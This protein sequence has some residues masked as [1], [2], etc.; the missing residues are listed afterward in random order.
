[1]KRALLILGFVAATAVGL[2]T[3]SEVK[4]VP[5]YQ[6]PCFPVGNP[7]YKFAQW[8]PDWGYHIGNDICHQ[9]NIAVY[10]PADGVVVYSA[11]TPASYRW[12]NLILIEH[13]QPDG[14]IVVS[15]HGHLA[16]NRQV[17]AGQG[18]AKGQLI[19]FVGA[20]GV[21]NGSWDPHNHFGIH[22]GPYNYP[23]GAYAPWVHG[24]EPRCCAGWVNSLDYARDR[25][26]AHDNIP[27]DVLGLTEMTYF[28]KLKLNFRARNTG[29]Q[30][31]K[32][33]GPTPTRLGTLA[34]NDRPSVFSKNGTGT[35]WVG[36][37]RI[38]L[39]ADTPPEG[40]GEFE[41]EFTSHEQPGQYRECFN[42]VTDNVGWHPNRPFC[43]TINLLA[44]RYHAQYDHQ[45]T[46]SASDPANR[47]SLAS[48]NYMLP[49]QT[50]NLKAYI[51][52][53]GELPWDVGPGN[54]VRLGTS[55]PLDRGSA[56]ATGGNT[57]IPNSENWPAANRASFIDGRYDPISGTITPVAAGDQITMDQIAVF[58]FT[59]TA[60]QTPGSYREYFNP[61]LEGKQWLN[62][63]GMYFPL[64]VLDNGHHYEHVSQNNPPPVGDST[65]TVTAKVRLRNS[66]QTSWPV[67]GN[68]RLGTDRPMDSASGFHAPS[69]PD[70]W[71][72]PTRLSAVD[73]NITTPGKTSIDPG[74]IAE[75]EFPMKIPPDLPAGTY[76]QYVRPVV[77]GVAWFPEDYGMYV[78]VTITAPP[79]GY[80]H[81][82]QTY[83]G[84][85]TNFV[86]G[87]TMTASIAIKNTGRTPWQASGPNAVRLGTSKPN[88]RV[89]GFAVTTGT[90]PWPSTNRATA[91][92]G[93]VTNLNTLATVT[94]TQINPGEIALFK[95][96]L[97]AN[98]PPGAYKEYFNL[99]VEGT[100]WLNDIGIHIP[101]TVTAPPPP[102]PTPSPSPT[103]PAQAGLSAP[104]AA[105]TSAANIR[106]NSPDIRVMTRWVA[107]HTGTLTTLHMRIQGEGATCW[108][109]DPRTG[110][111]AGNGGSWHVTTHPVL[112]DGRP[113]TA[114]T[115]AVQDFRPCTASSS[116]VGLGGAGIVK[117]PFSLTVTKGQ[118]YATVISNTDPDAVNNY[119]STNHLYT[120]GGLSGANSRNERSATAS[121]AHYS[122]DPREL[123]GYSV[124]GGSTWSLPGGQYGTP[125]GRNFLPTYI[126]EYG[127]GY[128][129]GQQFYYATAATTADKTMVYANFT[130][131]WTISSL[132]A[133]SL[134]GGTGTL[135][136]TVNGV[137]RASV[138]VTGSGMLRSAITP[139]TVQPGQIVKVTAS[140]LS[141]QN[142]V[143]D[144][145]WGHVMGMYLNT[146]KYLEYEPNFTHLAPVYPL[147]GPPA[148]PG[149]SS[150]SGG[151]FAPTSVWNTPL[152]SN[153]P[154]EPR[155]EITTAFKNQIK[156]EIG[157][158][159]GP[160]INIY[161]YS[162]PLYT[163]GSNQSRVKVTLD[164]GAWNK[165]MQAALLDVPI[166][167]HAVPAEGT[168]GHLTVWQ[169]STD[170]LWE[171]WQAKRQADGWH[172][173]YGGRMR[174][175]SQNPGH[176]IDTKDFT[177]AITEQAVWGATATSLPVIAGTITID[178]LKKGKIE[179]A[180]ALNI[181]DPC[182]DY[183]S[184]P[185]QRDDGGSTANDCLPEGA[186]LRI[187]P[188]LDLSTLD[189][190]P[191]TRMLAEA[192]QKYG[193]IV[194]D[195]TGHATGFSAED[196][197]PTGTD[198]YKG[199]GGF[200]GGLQIWDLVRNKFPWDHV[201]LLKLH[202][203]T[204]APCSRT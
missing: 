125:G 97:Q 84:S 34:P 35:G 29:H 42:L 61:V 196:P 21:Q 99:V 146:S 3:A 126:Q 74:E 45:Q 140:G 79:Y 123:V 107:R 41:A 120:Q 32:A 162:T 60:P 127:D 135:T 17:A 89:S 71:L 130:Q 112:S 30:T 24:Y 94:A 18:V 82:K 49:G 4:A 8:V 175:V 16:D 88:D 67:N 11:R 200:F 178:E 176:F 28:G 197:A 144:T 68:V 121:D 138:P 65:S 85:N 132:G 59:V 75:F 15:L 116:I 26:I 166:P 52:N 128:K 86:Q 149:T 44:K 103:S 9:E 87:S 57:S 58:S 110:Y 169:P 31:W 159:I 72:A 111:G 19:G 20:Q 23:V 191:F 195:K 93:R 187:D 171:F 164:A 158:G 145:A 66:G 77:D 70:P 168:D 48:G 199:P 192:A 91:I 151:L 106:L 194:R 12:G 33:D 109:P 47:T 53:S 100:A 124:D 2:V 131:P 183:F 69:A 43:P 37:N 36:T 105:G 161:E 202:P 113:D 13:R 180:L 170:T 22:G 83:S 101:L 56:W 204:Q 134:A 155:T 177:G 38:K 64:R 190:P 193:M 182:A 39:K 186:H 160:W 188:N 133:Y 163:V 50:V 5:G 147:P 165:P 55:N 118:E 167:D 152:P 95:F 172:A 184:W 189:M 25:R 156:K 102:P 92:D 78:P 137:T 150:V 154:L 27:I 117:I 139:V 198:P 7:N 98:R 201:K 179:H 203:C 108:P 181:P 136:L 143:A 148:Q 1:M 46:I 90:D 80:Q 104:V 76:Q 114:T 62:D 173:S 129:D 73:R 54:Q 40:V 174:N 122:L 10:A 63:L 81:Q 6:Q 115:L 51:K 185:A 119:M 141:L 14:G 96:P 153:A 157:A 142:V